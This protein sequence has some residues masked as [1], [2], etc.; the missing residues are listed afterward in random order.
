MKKK[1]I[2]LIIIFGVFSI[3]I[4]VSAKTYNLDEINIKANLDEWW[5]TFTRDNLDNNKDLSFVDVTKEYMEDYFK[6]NNAYLDAIYY[7]ED[8]EYIELT[9]QKYE[10]NE[11]DFLKS[12]AKIKNLKKAKK[13]EIGSLGLAL[14]KDSSIDNQLIYENDNCL[15]IKNYYDLDEYYKLSYVTIANNQ[16][17]IMSFTSNTQFDSTAEKITDAVID[18]VTIEQQNNNTITYIIVAIGIIIF[19]V[20]L[21]ICFLIKRP[22][23]EKKK[24]KKKI[25]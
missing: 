7:P 14:A 3:F 13:T 8:D 24:S 2:F 5:F 1:T 6:K 23:E 25:K 21:V 20:I 11:D 16:Y 18:D 17:Y 4:N 15:Y 9:I 10:M 22:K 19:I 12:F